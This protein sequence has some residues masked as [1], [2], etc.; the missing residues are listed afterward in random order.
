M[1]RQLTEWNRVIDAI[2]KMLEN[3]QPPSLG[4]LRCK[5]S[6]VASHRLLGI[7]APPSSAREENRNRT[8]PQLVNVAQKDRRAA[9]LWFPM[10]T[11]LSHILGRSMTSRP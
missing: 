10:Q 11:A 4:L 8:P 1:S 7:V 9:H 3:N 2:K 5:A 6:A